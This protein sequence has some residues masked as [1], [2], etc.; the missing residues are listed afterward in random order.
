MNYLDII[1]FIVTYLLG[2]VPFGLILTKCFLGVDVREV[3]SGNIGATNVYR[4]GS[5]PIAILTLIMDGLKGI[6]AVLLA[7][8]MGLSDI[9]INYCGF[10]CIIGHMYPIW[11]KFK[12]GKGVATTIAVVL[13]LTPLTGIMVILIWLATF[14]YKRISSLA[15]VIA[16]IFL[17]LI[18]AIVDYSLSIV[19]IYF[20]ISL[21]ILFKHTDNIKRLCNGEEKK[22]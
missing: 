21:L 10:L 7:Q 6:F 3:G 12:G 18:A 4:T 17:T 11:L 8:K 15:S 1:I 13:T 2:S 19:T 22:I 14:W 20:I 9:A 5:K 16:T